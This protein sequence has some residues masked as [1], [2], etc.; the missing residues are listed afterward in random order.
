MTGVAKREFLGMILERVKTGCDLHPWS[1]QLKHL[2][3]VI[4]REILYTVT[5]RGKGSAPV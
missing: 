3:P 4:E 2:A 5:V 1:K